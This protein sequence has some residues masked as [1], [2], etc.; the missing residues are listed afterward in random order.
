MPT[1]TIQRAV[2]ATPKLVMTGEEL[3]LVHRCSACGGYI[4]GTPVIQCDNCGGTLP[5][6]CFVY[7]ARNRNFYAECLDLS[8]IA[9][10]STE[11]EAIGRLQE[12]MYG[13]CHTVIEGGGDTRGLLPRRAPL[14]SWIHYYAKKLPIKLLYWLRRKPQPR[15]TVQVPN[16]GV[17]RPNHC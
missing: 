6:R 16:L 5:L 8:L 11:E 15:H 2:E 9:R 3:R 1:S 10:G 13:Y 17:F 14:A 4:I 7:H 12:E